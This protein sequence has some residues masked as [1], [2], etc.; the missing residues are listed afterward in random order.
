MIMMEV[1]DP[2][3]SSQA[4]QE[5]AGEEPQPK[6]RRIEIP[7]TQK[8]ISQKSEIIG[9]VKAADR[10]GSDF[11]TE[12]TFMENSNMLDE[13]HGHGGISTVRNQGLK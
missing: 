5:I 11:Q 9:V 2:I 4:L 10:M 8:I 3:S 13:S 1:T 12:Q 7:A 6:S